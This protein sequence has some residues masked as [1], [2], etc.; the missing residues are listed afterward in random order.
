MQAVL[1]LSGVLFQEMP[2]RKACAKVG[3]PFEQLLYPQLATGERSVS[4][5]QAFDLIALADVARREPEAVAFLLGETSDWPGWRGA[6]RGT[7]FLVEFER[8]LQA[9]GHRG[10][11]E[12]DWALPRY[13]EDP[14][15]LFHALRAHLQEGSGKAPSDIAVRQ[16]R[17]S[18]EAWAA[19]TE[20]LSPW[21]RRTM[22]PRVRRAIRTV[23]QYYVW[24]EKVRSDMMRVIEPVRMLHLVLADRFVERGWL[25]FRED[26]FLID[27]AD[28]GAV[29]EGRRTP[30]TLRGIAARRA[31]ERARHAALSMPLLMRESQLDQLI[32]TAGVSERS[33]DESQ[34]RGF[35]VSGGT[36][37]AEV[38]VVRD[39]GDFGRMKRGAILVAPATD[40]SW[41]PL[42]TLASGVIVEVGGVLSHASTI[43]REYG[44]PALANVKHA[45]K[46]LRTGERV[47]LDAVRGVV[48]RLD[49]PGAGI[50]SP[51]LD[52][53]AA[54]TASSR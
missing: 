16:E 43:A 24:R 20:R 54:R 51:A 40:P 19:F 28:I 9:Y 49:P 41:T 3:F 46:R 18:A 50:A 39:P 22:L 11:Y 47:R 7:A 44:L 34:L 36:V 25:D 53:V 4:A 33:A 52:A 17:E 30:E 2:V 5:Q 45:T 48:T 15:P 32:R 14:A 31:G 1:V 27:L 37:E 35:P 26:Y 42:F 21:Q 38:V 6:L 8:F 10:R 23:K 13:R 12:S 29:L